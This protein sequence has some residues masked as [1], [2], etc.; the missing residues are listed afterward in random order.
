MFL[1]CQEDFGFYLVVHGILR[2]VYTPG[3]FIARQEHP[4]D[5]EPVYDIPV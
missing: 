2:N 4:C 5:I 1:P 3:D